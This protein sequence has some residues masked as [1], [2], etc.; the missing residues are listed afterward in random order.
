MKALIDIKIELDDEDYQRRQRCEAILDEIS[1]LD[2]QAT[3]IKDRMNALAAERATL[4]KERSVLY[5]T[6]DA[7]TKQFNNEGL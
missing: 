3:A 1:E 7:F 2:S 6:R 4:L 5:G